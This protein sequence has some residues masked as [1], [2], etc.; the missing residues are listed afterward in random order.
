MNNKQQKYI[1]NFIYM[2]V[3]LL[4]SIYSQAFEGITDKITEEHIIQA[5]TSNTEGIP[6]SPSRNETQSTDASRRV[7]SGV[8]H[9][10]MYTRLEDA[11]G[12][13]LI[14]VSSVDRDALTDRLMANPLVKVVGRSEIEDYERLR[15]FVSKFNELGQLIAYASKSNDDHKNKVLDIIEKLSNA[16]NAG[17]KNSFSLSLI[18]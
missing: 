12:S 5:I 1:R 17:H 2:N 13:S 4:Y 15:V 18:N 3:P 8:L 16:A 14:D 10:H 6:L 9:D 7:E 11:L